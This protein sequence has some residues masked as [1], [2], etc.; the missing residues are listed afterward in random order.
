MVRDVRSAQAMDKRDVS[1][2]FLPRSIAIAGTLLWALT[3]A[4]QSQAAPKEQDLE[5]KIWTSNLNDYEALERLAVR[6]LQINAGA[7]EHYLIAELSLR[8]FKHNPSELRYLK[9]ASEMSQQAIE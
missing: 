7:Y 2:K 8:M 3:F 9:V 5:N 6:K 4:S 1:G